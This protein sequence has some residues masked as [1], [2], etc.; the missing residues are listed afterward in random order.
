MKASTAYSLHVGVKRHG[1][2]RPASCRWYQRTAR[3]VHGFSP[4]EAGLI[5]A[6]PESG[7]TSGAVRPTRTSPRPGTPRSGS[8][9]TPSAPRRPPS[10]QW[11]GVADGA[12]RARPPARRVG[13]WR[14]PHA[15]EWRCRVDRRERCT[16]GLRPGPGDPR[17][18]GA[19]KSYVSGSARSRR[20]AV[21]TLGATGLEHRPTGSGAHPGTESVLHRPAALV[22]LVGALHAALLGPPDG[23]ARQS[24]DPPWDARGRSRHDR[25]DY[26]GRRSAATAPVQTG[27]A[28][29]LACRPLRSRCPHSVDKSVDERR[30]KGQ[31]RR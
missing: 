5:G 11:P 8:P 10:L 21:T 31:N 17:R 7:R 20:E 23:A 29:L 4:A 16:T 22:G 26:G 3:T 19:G 24:I 9:P 6:S 18:R 25:Q 13:R 14:T 15:G 30:R 28:H 1:L 2:G 27:A 12:G